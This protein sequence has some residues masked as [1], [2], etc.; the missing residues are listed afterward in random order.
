MFSFSNDKYTDSP[1]EQSLISFV[2]GLS[3]RLSWSPPVISNSSIIPIL[4]QI[5][6]ARILD[7][8]VLTLNTVT[9]KTEITLRR[10]DLQ[11]NGDPETHTWSVVA[12]V[13]GT[14]GTSVTASDNF[15]FNQ[16]KQ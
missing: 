12:V 13:G 1:N 3:V 14:A 11:E 2:N 6:V 4:Y 10:C 7:S 15:T 16:C 8:R 9:N 5:F